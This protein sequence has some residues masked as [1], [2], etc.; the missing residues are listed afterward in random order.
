MQLYSIS[1]LDPN[2]DTSSLCRVF[3]SKPV[4]IV[5]CCSVDSLNVHGAVEVDELCFVVRYAVYRII[6][7]EP[8]LSFSFAA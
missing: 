7:R 4:D 6:Q 3:L 8:K 2:G 5:E 1:P